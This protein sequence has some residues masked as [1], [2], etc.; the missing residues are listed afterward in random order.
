[1]TLRHA[2]NVREGIRPADFKV[3]ERAIGNPPLDKGPNKDVTLDMDTLTR[4]FYNETQ[5]DPESG[6]PD[7][8]KLEK[9]E[10]NEVIGALY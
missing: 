6:M 8:S 2:F 10:L 4:A 1:M 5:W 9:L 7:R 3:A